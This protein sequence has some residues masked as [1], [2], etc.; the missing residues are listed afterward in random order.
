MATLLASKHSH[1]SLAYCV[2]ALF[3]LDIYPLPAL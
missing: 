1:I 3:I 2:P